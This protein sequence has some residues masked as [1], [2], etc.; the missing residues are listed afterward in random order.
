M[1]PQEEQ[2]ASLTMLPFLLRV[3]RKLEKNV[4][5]MTMVFKE[6]SPGHRA[7]CQEDDVILAMDSATN[8]V[9]HYQ[10]TQGLKRF[11]FPMVCSVRAAGERLFVPLSSTLLTPG[12]GG[13]VLNA[14]ICRTER[15]K[16]HRR[17]YTS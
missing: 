3:R 2:R 4:S 10:K 7:R 14:S 5:V 13:A 6:S 8:R 16:W 1:S 15:G 11:P 12:A 17:T 9:L